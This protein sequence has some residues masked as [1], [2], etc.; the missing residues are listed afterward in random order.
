[1]KFRTTII[2]VILAFFLALFKYC[3]SSKTSAET[4]LPGKTATD[5]DLN[6][7][8]TQLE[9]KVKKLSS[10]LSKVVKTVNSL[11]KKVRTL[12]ESEPGGD[13]A[14]KVGA[15]EMRV[16]EMDST[17]AQIKGD[18]SYLNNRLKMAENRAQYADSINFEIL[19]Q[20]VILENRILSMSANLT[21]YNEVS[22]GA[23]EEMEAVASSYK[24]RYLQA[25][26]LHQSNRNDDAIAMFRRLISEDMK[27]G[28]SDNAQYWIGECYYSLKQY[29]RAIVEFQKVFSFASTNKDDDAQFKLG[30][31]YLAL[32][33]AEK[34]RDAF[35]RLID[36]FPNSEY[37]GKT[38]QIMK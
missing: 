14:M 33:D 17:I 35:Q 20:L 37:V 18:L 19:S 1:M 3:G 5:A 31:C 11:N 32:G 8:V 10:S 15:L 23:S 6:Q 22:E 9:T 30:L 29:Q 16:L 12:G 26:K 38:K 13:Y 7:K 24:D 36:Y 25:L 34:A 28:L 27:H 4:L 21:E 2:L